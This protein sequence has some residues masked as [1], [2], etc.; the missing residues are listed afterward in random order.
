MEGQYD[1]EYDLFFYNVN[2]K[3]HEQLQ[4][5]NIPHDFI[6][7]PGAHN[8]E[9]WNNAIKYQLLYFNEYFNKVGK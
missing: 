1:C 9:Y 2:I 3:L 8:W 7:R 5:S 4:Y 6:I